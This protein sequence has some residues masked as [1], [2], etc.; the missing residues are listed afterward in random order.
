MKLT[1]LALTLALSATAALANDHMKEIAA[2]ARELGSDYQKMAKTLKDKNF[3]E[4]ELLEELKLAETELEKIQGHMSAFQ[5]SKPALGPAQ[6]K[7]WK[8]T[9]DLVQ[10]LDIFHGRKAVLLEGD[11]PHKRRAD[12][13]AEAQ[14]LVTRA[15]MLVQTATRLSALP[16]Q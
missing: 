15:N 7:D 12:L 2:E 10:L 9:Q 8:T 14:A 13:L 5:A 4:R 6:T 16:N 3:P 1:T 11:N